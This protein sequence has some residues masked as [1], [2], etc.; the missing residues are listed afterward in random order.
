MD[1]HGPT[2][3]IAG[4]SNIYPN[5]DFWFENK[6]SGNPDQP[7]KKLNR[8]SVFHCWRKYNESAATLIAENP[9]YQPSFSSSGQALKKLIP[10]YIR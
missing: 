3:S 6:P 5:L 7:C 9:F 8:K 1:Q 4:P 10:A 2:C